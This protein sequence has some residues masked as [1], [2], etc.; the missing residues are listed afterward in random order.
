MPIT[1]IGTQEMPVE[2]EAPKL[3]EHGFDHVTGMKTKFSF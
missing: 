3:K 2:Q 1:S